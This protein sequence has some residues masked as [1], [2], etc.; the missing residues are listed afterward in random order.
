MAFGCVRTDNMSGTTLGKDLVSLRYFDK[1]GKEAEI[2]NGCVVLIGEYLEGQREVRKATDVAKN[3]P[4]NKVALVA[5]EEVDKAKSYN[6]LSEFKNKAGADVR[7]YRVGCPANCFSVT[8]ECFVAGGHF[9]VGAIV[10][11]ADGNKFAVVE[12]A[13]SGSTK[14]GVITAVEDMWYVVEVDAE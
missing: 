1:S 13:T 6:A 11:L 5:S 8:K 12:S 2:E 7:G 4:L 3:S 14:V 9:A 10:E